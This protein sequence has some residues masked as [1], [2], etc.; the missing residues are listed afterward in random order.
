MSKNKTKIRKYTNRKMYDAST[1]AYVSMLALSDR[2]AGGDSVEVTCDRTGRDITLKVLARALYERLNA[3]DDDKSFS[4]AILERLI[5]R[6][7]ARS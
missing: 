3:S 5:A 1:A 4:P 2:V 6:V 7:P